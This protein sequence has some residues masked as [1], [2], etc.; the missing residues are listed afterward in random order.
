MY[1]NKITL[2]LLLLLGLAA[3]SWALRSDRQ[4]AIEIRADRVE[5]DERKEVSHYYGNVKMEQGSLKI[6]ADEVVVYLQDGALNKIVIYGNPAHFEQ[7]PDDKKTVVESRAEHMEYFARNQLLVLRRNAQV[8]Q[9]AN[10][11]SGDLIEYDTLKSTVRATK[12][13]GS[14][15]R[16]HAIIQPA[17]DKEDEK[18]PEGAQK[19]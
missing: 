9:G 12:D 19:P 2:I 7:Q 11:F 15:T 4:Q 18:T 6:R 10:L 17:S 8:K 16:V 5:I 1:L 3:Q 13:E 14:D